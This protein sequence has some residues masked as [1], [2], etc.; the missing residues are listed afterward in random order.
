VTFADLVDGLRR[1]RDAA[2]VAA[3]PVRLPDVDDLRAAWPALD[4]AAR[5]LVLSAATESLTIARARPGIN[6]FDEERV[7]WVAR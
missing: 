2:A 3:A 5:R 4:L 6:R 7:R 1:Q